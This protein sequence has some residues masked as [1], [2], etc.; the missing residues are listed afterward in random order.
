MYVYRYILKLFKK[1]DGIKKTFLFYINCFNNVYGFIISNIL[2]K[3]ICNEI[4]EQ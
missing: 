4:N 1:N 3:Y 2:Y